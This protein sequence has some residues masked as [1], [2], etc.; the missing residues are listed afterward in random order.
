[1]IYPYQW[2]L[3]ASLLDSIIC[4]LRDD[5]CNAILVSV[6]L[7][8]NLGY[9]LC[10]LLFQKIQLDN[11]IQS[12]YTMIRILFLISLSNDLTGADDS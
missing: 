6:I 9:S 1:M 7:G 8:P 11:L 2:I 3:L 5:S 10:I 4:I 12:L